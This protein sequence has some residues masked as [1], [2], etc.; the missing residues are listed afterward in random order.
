MD[1]SELVAN[2]RDAVTVGR[3]FAE[4][5][6]KDGTVVIVAARVSGGAGGGTGQDPKGQEGEGG[7]F[8]ISAVPA[9]AYVIRDGSVRWVP[10]LNPGRVI[11]AAAAVAITVVLT[12]AWVATRAIRAGQQIR[13]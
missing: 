10:A 2:A 11:A 7:G 4:P 8:G 1:V 12:R 5:Y 6:E 9:G 3:V 13:G